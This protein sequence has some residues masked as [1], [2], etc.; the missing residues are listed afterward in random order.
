MRSCRCPLRNAIQGLQE[1]RRCAQGVRYQL[2][3]PGSGE[4]PACYGSARAA[5]RPAQLLTCSHCSRG[6]GQEAGEPEDA[7]DARAEGRGHGGF[8]SSN[9][10]SGRAGRY[11][12]CEARAV[13]GDADTAL[14]LPRFGTLCCCAPPPPTASRTDPSP[15]QL[16]SPPPR[17]L[18][19]PTTFP[20]APRTVL[21]QSAPSPAPLSSPHF[22]SLRF[23]PTASDSAPQ[24]RRQHCKATSRPLWVLLQVPSPPLTLTA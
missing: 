3:N 13:R 7:A 6:Q 4:A 1:R 10:R 5:G 17:T 24:R 15:R 16:L 11:S 19:F 21:H 12:G 2:R 20:S 23:L 9:S 22:S 14:A 8:G 18:L